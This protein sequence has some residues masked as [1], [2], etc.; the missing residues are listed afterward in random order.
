MHERRTHCSCCSPSGILD[1]T[2]CVR[3]AVVRTI[4]H[5]ISHIEH[6]EQ[7]WQT[8]PFPG[9][10]YVLDFQLAFGLLVLFV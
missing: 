10:L 4:E 2:T 9:L 1:M 3:H 8:N 5:N 7:R 6:Y